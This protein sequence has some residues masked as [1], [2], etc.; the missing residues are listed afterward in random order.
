MLSVLG[1]LGLHV[2]CMQYSRGNMGVTWISAQTGAV[3]CGCFELHLLHMISL[4][5][6]GATGAGQGVL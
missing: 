5:Y 4:H 1:V 6:R 2:I 3:R